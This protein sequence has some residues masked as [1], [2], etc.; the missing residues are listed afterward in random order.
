MLPCKY[1]N[2]HICLLILCVLVYR[3]M[4]ANSIIFTYVRK[5]NLRL[6]NLSLFIQILQVS[7]IMTFGHSSLLNS[8]CLY[9][10]N[11]YLLLA[12]TSLFDQ[13]YWNW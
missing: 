1:I 2:K 7:L 13:K 9:I 3:Y 4:K 5:T 11:I 6:S 12:F 10:N 8:I